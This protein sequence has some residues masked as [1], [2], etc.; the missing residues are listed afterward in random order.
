MSARLAGVMLLLAATEA[1]ADL[2]R[3]LHL[4]PI[5]PTSP[6][7]VAPVAR[8]CRDAE[9]ALSRRTVIGA[10]EVVVLHDCTSSEPTTALLLHTAQGWFESGL[11]LIRFRGPSSFDRPLAI[12]L[13]DERVRGGEMEDGS[14]AVVHAVETLH[15]TSELCDGGSCPTRWIREYELGVQVCTLGEAP[16]CAQWQ[17]LCGS[18]RCPAARLTKGVLLLGEK[19][20]WVTR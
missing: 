15:R 8:Q 17:H 19:R 12:D 18:K 6:P 4:E 20:M 2:L 14:P 9:R 13:T 5:S 10:T 16:A 7:I 1:R 11:G 3:A